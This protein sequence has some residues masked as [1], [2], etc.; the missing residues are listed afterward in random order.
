MRLFE[1]IKNKKK[2]KRKK[3]RSNRMI[4]NFQLLT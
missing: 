3:L 1:P 4:D 2:K